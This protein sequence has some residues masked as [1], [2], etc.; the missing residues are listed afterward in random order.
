MSRIRR[1]GQADQL[2]EA[3]RLSSLIL[4]VK[5][6]SVYRNTDQTINASTVT[7]ISFSHEHIDTANMWSSGAATRLIVPEDGIY[8]ALGGWGIKDSATD[9]KRMAVLFR[10]DGA[11][12]RGGGEGSPANTTQA[13]VAGNMPALPLTA[14]QYVEVMAYHEQA[15]ART[16]WGG[17]IYNWG[18]LYKLV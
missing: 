13:V 4:G 17:A 12:Y 14:G 1:W 9:N 5:V 11:T 2:V 15:A 16:L 10:I 18:V 6:V 7:A 3:S 8:I